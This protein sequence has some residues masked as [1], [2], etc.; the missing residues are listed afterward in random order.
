VK[1]PFTVTSDPAGPFQWETKPA[2]IG[3]P[4]SQPAQPGS[5]QAATAPAAT[6]APATKGG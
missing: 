2:V 4:A 5:T 3:A 1:G 6:T